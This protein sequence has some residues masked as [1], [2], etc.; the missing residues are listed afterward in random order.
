MLRGFLKF[1]VCRE[2]HRE[3][4]GEREKKTASEIEMCVVAKPPY[5]LNDMRGINFAFISSAFVLIQHTNTN[6]IYMCDQL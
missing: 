6:A 3:R 5:N 2:R 1:N 4:E